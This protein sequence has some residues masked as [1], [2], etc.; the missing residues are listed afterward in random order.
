MKFLIVAFV[1]CVLLGCLAKMERV[2][3]DTK[4]SVDETKRGQQLATALE[5][6]HND[7]ISD[8]AMRAAAA[9][10][11]F[12]LAP[13]DRI[14]KYLGCRL[15]LGIGTDPETGRPNVTFVFVADQDADNK[16]VPLVPGVSAP[17]SETVYALLE[18]AT[19]SVL[20]DL[21][22]VA[23]RD[24]SA[25]QLE[26]YRSKVTR[27][28]PIATAI[29]GA[30]VH[31]HMD[32]YYRDQVPTLDGRGEAMNSAAVRA[33]GAEL[34]FV[35]SAKYSLGSEGVN[36]LR[37]LVSERLGLNPDFSGDLEK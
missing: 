5:I 13:D 14:H 6:L 16:A 7:D 35:V 11:V 24:L 32:T 25:D 21:K 37:V 33:Q 27:M 10:T 23:N 2:T 4:N 30:R 31:T 18:H 28:I 9:E 20:K 19:L 17:K 1:S 8:M 3:E 22:A 36:A 12:M 29:L 15:P 26:D 34:L